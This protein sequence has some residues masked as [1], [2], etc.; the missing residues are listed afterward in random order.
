[1]HY[2]YG[3]IT[4]LVQ[5]FA[6]ELFDLITPSMLSSFRCL[7]ASLCLFYPT[8]KRTEL[9]F[10]YCPKI[11]GKFLNGTFTYTVVLQY[12]LLAYIYFYRC[13]RWISAL[14]VIVLLS[15]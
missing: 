1:M 10:K 3:A 8:D 6:P 13:S 5:N 2:N 12:S 7:I 9:D 11:V 14:K 4:L 15:S